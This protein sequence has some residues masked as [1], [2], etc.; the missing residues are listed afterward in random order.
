MATNNRVNATLI[1]RNSSPEIWETRNPILQLGEYGL[2]YDNQAHTLLLK[3]GDGVRDW[4]HLPY[5]NK[6]DTEYFQKSVEDGTIT[7]SDEFQ[8]TI[9]ALEAAAGQAI[10]HLTITD[11][12]VNPTDVPNKQYV[13]DQIAQAGMLKRAIVESLPDPAQADENTMYMVPAASG[14]YYEEYML[15]NGAWDM[16]GETGDGGS[17]GF[18]LEIATSAKLGGVKSAPL[19]GQGNVLKDDD[20]IVVDNNTGFMTLNQVSTSL[21]YVPTGDTLVIYGG[22][23]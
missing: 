12:P 4:E 2:E 17:G 7:F 6:Y 21:L 10:E 14:N 20:Y 8:Q 19:D 15:I 1:I 16:V 9:E 5:L 13:D 3:I 18:T 23:A 22:T 11:P